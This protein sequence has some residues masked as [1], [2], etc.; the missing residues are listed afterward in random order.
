[1]NIPLIGSSQAF[2]NF[3]DMYKQIKE[4]HINLVFISSVNEIIFYKCITS[5]EQS[6]IV[7]GKQSYVLV[8]MKVFNQ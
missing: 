1:M 8:I 3:I 2:I 6:Y 5:R 4:G 7:Y